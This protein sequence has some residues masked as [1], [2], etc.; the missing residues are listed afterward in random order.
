VQETP[1]SDGAPAGETSERTVE[2]IQA[3]LAEE[4][5]ELLGR[6]ALLG[7]SPTPMLLLRVEF[8][9]MRDFLFNEQDEARAAYDAACDLNLNEQLKRAIANKVGTKLTVVGDAD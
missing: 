9:T 4:N 2:Q 7:M 5:T 1:P 3:E 8:D 6:L